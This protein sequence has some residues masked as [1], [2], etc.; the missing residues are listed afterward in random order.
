ME[1]A[2]HHFISTISPLFCFQNAKFLFTNY[3]HT[4]LLPN[5]QSLPN[6]HFCFATPLEFLTGPRGAVPS[7]L[8]TTALDRCNNPNNYEKQASRTP[9]F[10]ARSMEICCNILTTHRKCLLWSKRRYCCTVLVLFPPGQLPIWYLSFFYPKQPQTK[11]YL[12]GY[13]SELPVFQ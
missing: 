5:R 9:F 12:I 13:C 8:G 1:T 10:T 4:C 2:V 7:T 3:M 6:R 11:P